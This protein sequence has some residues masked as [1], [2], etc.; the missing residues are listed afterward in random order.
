MKRGRRE[1]RAG[2]DEAVVDETGVSVGRL[3]GSWLAR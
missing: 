2:R 3:A 1:C